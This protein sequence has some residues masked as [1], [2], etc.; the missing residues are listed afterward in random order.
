MTSVLPTLQQIP[1][2]VQN[3]TSDTAK[4]ANSIHLPLVV[5]LDG[6]LTPTDTLAELL[7][8]LLKHSPMTL[9]LL[10]FWLLQ[11]IAHVKARVAERTRFSASALPYRQDVLQFL[12]EQKE[13]GRTLVLATA[14]H[15]SIAQAVADHLGL[16]DQVLGSTATRNL[17]GRRKLAAIVHSVG[18]AFVYAGDSQAD[19]P[20]WRAARAAVLVNVRSGLT[21]SVKNSVPVEREFRGP[22]AQIKI[23]AKALRMHQWV[24]NSLIFVPLITGFSFFDLASMVPVFLAFLA[25]SFAA[26]ATY[27]VNDLSDLDNDRAHA[28]K[29]NRPFASCAIGIFPGIC[30]AV[31][32]IISA[33]VIATQVSPGFLVVLLTY[34]IITSAYTLSLKKYVLID[35]LVLS[36]LYT[37]RIV[38]GAFA[39]GLTMSSWLLAFSV[40]IFFSLALVKRCSELVHLQASGLT[41]AKG[42]DYKVTDLVILWPLGIGAALSSVVVFG[43]FISASVTRERYATP[44]V[45]WLVALGLI[46]WLGRLWI[47]TARGEMHDDPIVYALKNDGSRVIIAICITAMVFGHLFDFCPR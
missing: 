14:A 3:A 21:K 40:F 37:I 2:R 23:W 13:A 36:V 38:A 20:I 47:A 6:T 44:E 27:I 17:K 35:V 12:V 33:F 8:Q 7:I 9:F 32:L 18:E 4:V 19:L 45:L 26:S 22:C 24:K 43:L 16:F 11:G 42:R 39:V 1:L 25:F 29:R 41:S 15:E 5:D 31:A 10:P 28:R 46:Y 30:A 34:V